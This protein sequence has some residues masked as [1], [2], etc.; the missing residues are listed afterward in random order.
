[1]PRRGL[2]GGLEAMVMPSPSMEGGST[3]GWCSML[4][5]ATATL[6]ES[7]SHHGGSE[8]RRSA[9]EYCVD[10]DEGLDR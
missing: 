3:S 4:G 9:C 8:A 5:A 10:V 7:S 1:M 6:V 2:G